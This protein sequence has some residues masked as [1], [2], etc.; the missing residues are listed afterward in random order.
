[1]QG[2]WWDGRLLLDA[3]PRDTVRLD[4]CYLPGSSQEDDQ[5]HTFTLSEHHGVSCSP[6]IRTGWTLYIHERHVAQI[7]CVGESRPGAAVGSDQFLVAPDEVR[8][9]VCFVQKLKS[10]IQECLS[11]SP[12]PFAQ[13]LSK[14]VVGSPAGIWAPLSAAFTSS[15]R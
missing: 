9:S 5:S 7:G 8:L 4:S 6:T 12:E 1:L 3:E 2:S 15:P 11:L 10:Q 14:V 13:R